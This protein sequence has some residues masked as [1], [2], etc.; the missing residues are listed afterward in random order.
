MCMHD[1]LYLFY[2]GAIWLLASI[3]C[4]GCLIWKCLNCFSEKS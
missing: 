2:L 1:L 3:Y 4:V